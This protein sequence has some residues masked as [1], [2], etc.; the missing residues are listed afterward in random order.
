[1]N[2]DSMP[3]RLWDN[4]WVTAAAGGAAA[5][6]ALWLGLPWVS[7]AMSIATILLLRRAYRQ[8]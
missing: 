6:A 5:V 1:M 8:S 4:G 7:G 3:A 2:D